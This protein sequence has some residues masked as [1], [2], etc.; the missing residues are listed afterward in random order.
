MR[1]PRDVLKRC[2]AIVGK[3]V[4]TTREIRTR[5][6][7][8]YPAGTMWRV[9]S[10]WRGSFAITGITDDGRTQFVQPGEEKPT[11]G[12]QIGCVSRHVRGVERGA[13][14]LVDGVPDEP[15]EED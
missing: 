9:S 2:K 11:R 15:K 1:T 8:V 4:R 3:A 10:T 14:D 5:G 6:G 13:F 12:I 7:D